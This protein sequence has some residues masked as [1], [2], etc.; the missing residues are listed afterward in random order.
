MSLSDEQKA[1]ILDWV[2]ACQSAYHIDS[3]P[4]HRF[5]GLG[6]SLAENQQ[7]LLEYIEEVA[8]AIERAATIAAMRRCAEICDELEEHWSDYK[9]T[10]L[11]NGDVE[12]S[13]AASG[14]PRAARSI[15]AAIRAE[16]ARLEAEK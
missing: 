14:E 12:L 11:L 3:T 1:E 8:R 16:I 10:A 15:A 13:N 5:G 2:R 4:G 9:D 7:A 6:S